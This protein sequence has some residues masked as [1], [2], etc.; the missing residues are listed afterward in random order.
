MTHY[1]CNLK[2]LLL[3]INFA[4][5]PSFCSC[6]SQFPHCWVQLKELVK[7]KVVPFC[8][9]LG[10]RKDR[11]TPPSTPDA[12]ARKGLVASDTPHALG[13]PRESFRKYGP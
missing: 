1:Q 12:G 2:G 7:V 6:L 10:K 11:G 8:A 13:G 9:K 4:L 5:A 3:L